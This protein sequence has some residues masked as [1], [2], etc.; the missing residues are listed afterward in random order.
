MVQTRKKYVDE[1]HERL[2]RTYKTPED[3]RPESI[4]LLND[5][6]NR[7]NDDLIWI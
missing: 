3:V 6:L 5:W 1:P 7:A 4:Q 2:Q